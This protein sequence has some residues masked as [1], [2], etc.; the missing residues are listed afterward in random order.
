MRD[1]RQRRTIF[2]APKVKAWLKRHQLSVVLIAAAVII[3]TLFIVG[4]SSITPLQNNTVYTP[5]KI[6]QKFYSPLTGSRVTNESDTTLPVTAVMIENSPE[7]RPQSGLKEA[8]VVYEAVAEGGVTRFL[9]L[10]QQEKPELIGP[11]RSLRM[12]YLDWAAPYQA[13]IAHVGGS[14]NALAEVRNGAYRDID[15]FFNAGTYWRST[16]RYAPHN[17]YTSA[18]RLAQLNDAK[19][20]T[21][22][23]FSSFDR[24]DG[25]PVAEPNATSIAVNFG[26]AP[27]NTTYT[28]NAESNSYDRSLAGSPHE[29]PSHGR[30]SPT[31][32]V[33]LKVQSQSR[34]GPDNYEDITTEG[35][36]EAHIFQNGTVIQATWKK[37][38]RLSPLKLV[39]GD[40]TP[41]ELGR[42]QT[43]IGAV[44]SRG[45]VSWQ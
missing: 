13:S 35:Q 2:S 18:E 30:I 28:Y 31:V 21:S 24:V 36:G 6:Q 14:P 40:G 38:N 34:G 11:V 17:V 37:D 3:A 33:A 32:V 44:T 5:P 22:S 39:S 7:S 26:G 16:D 8:G 42:G 27:Y 25:K 19:D 41:I 1:R 45:S 15:E 4:V 43:W 9:A 29:D 23:E 20:Y 12:Y 10:Y